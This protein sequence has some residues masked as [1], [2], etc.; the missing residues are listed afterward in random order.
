[1]SR[2]QGRRLVSTTRF[3][4]KKEKSSS[5]N[6]APRLSMRAFNATYLFPPHKIVWAIFDEKNW[7]TAENMH[8]LVQLASDSSQTSVCTIYRGSTWARLCSET[9]QRVESTKTDIRIIIIDSF[10]CQLCTYLEFS[11]TS[12]CTWLRALYLWHR[13]I[14]TFFICLRF[15]L[16]FPC[17]RF[18]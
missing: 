16:P 11:R 4:P 1:M 8:I 3:W 18:L 5:K 13:S 10:E 9:S 12:P 7:L 15:F 17:L 6:W 14:A 2:R